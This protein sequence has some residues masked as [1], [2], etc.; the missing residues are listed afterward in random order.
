MGSRPCVRA[1]AH[2]SSAAA[3]SLL[4]ERCLTSAERQL[5]ELPGLHRECLH[6]AA[7][8]TAARPTN[9]TKVS[10]SRSLDPLDI[11]VLDT[12]LHIL[13]LLESWSE[14]VVE[15]RGAAAPR[16]RVPDLARFLAAHL[17]WLT[18]QPP[19]A[20]FADE[21][22]A[23]VREL[24]QIIDPDRGE[25]FTFVHACV[26]DGCG[27]TITAALRPGESVPGRSVACSAGHAW[28]AHEWL[29]L[30]HLM[31]VRARQGGGSEA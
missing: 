3:G 14:V 16:R 4:C 13:S 17:G 25:H 24:R 8:T 18:A 15:K 21:I 2:E 23:L 9:P 27:G 6:Q 31:A 12:R 7:P 5:R 28:E 20:E 22:E 26:Q 19:A 10:A 30:R 29:R 1:H 11:S